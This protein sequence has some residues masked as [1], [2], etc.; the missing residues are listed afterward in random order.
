MMSA[1]AA[2]SIEPVLLEG[3]A[4][5]IFVIYY[6][7]PA[8]LENGLAFVH[9]PAFAD[10]M[11]CSRRMVALQARRLTEAG[12]GVLVLDL[13]GTGD[14]G[15]DFRDARWSIWLGDIAAAA[16]WLRAR[17]HAEIGLWG[18]R[19][20]AL[21]AMQAASENPAAYR[22]ML[23]WQPV[24]EG[25]TMLTQFL[26]L[27]VAHAMAGGRRE[28]T[29]DLRALLAAGQSI[30]VAG[31]ELSPELAEA[32]DATRIEPLGPPPQARVDWLEVASEP[33]RGLGPASRQILET[34]RAAGATVSAVSVQGQ[35]FWSIQETVLAPELLAATTRSLQP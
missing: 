27:R 23:L 4:G 35:P 30:E 28:T 8:G 3:T 7:P 16:A 32:I 25:R 6:P 1:R 10:E 31:Y 18:S 13:Y 19:L 22:Q 11:N 2:S 9:V 26:R 12:I 20:G 24:L 21:L 29:G 33:D 34:W 17:G 5:P 15:G 14:S